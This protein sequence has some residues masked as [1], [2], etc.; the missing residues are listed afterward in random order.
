MKKGRKKLRITINIGQK[1]VMAPDEIITIILTGEWQQDKREIYFDFHPTTN[2]LFPF[3]N[4][5]AN[6]NSCSLSE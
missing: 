3:A 1:A 6:L 4:S 2:P 5:T